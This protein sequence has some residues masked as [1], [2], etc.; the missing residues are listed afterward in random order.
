MS[1]F[2]AFGSSGGPILPPINK[3]TA[4]HYLQSPSGQYQLLLQEDSEFVLRDNGN[5]IWVAS[6]GQR[7]SRYYKIR[8]F[9]HPAVTMEGYLLVH[10]PNHK[11]YWCTTGFS[12]HGNNHDAARRRVFAVLQDDGNLVL[13]DR[14][15]LWSVNTSIWEFSAN[16]IGFR[17]ESG[18]PIEMGR[19]YVVEGARLV[20]QP[21]GELVAFGPSGNRLWG[22]GTQGKGASAAVMQPDGN[23]AISANGQLLWATNT[24][25][26][27]GAYVQFQNNGNLSVAIERPIWARFGLR[28]APKRKIKVWG[29]WSYPIFK[30]G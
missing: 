2:V 30:F 13:I 4:G 20:F 16:K 29:P 18:Q 24:A 14:V 19:E 27:P 17:F 9:D 22:S 26:N 6:D 12:I 3:M 10:Q 25:G 23:F 1:D 7:Y 8:K 11:R 15:P 28:Q 21:D 5:V